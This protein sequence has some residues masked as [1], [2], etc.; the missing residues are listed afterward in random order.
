[1]SLHPPKDALLNEIIEGQWVGLK[2]GDQFMVGKVTKLSLG[3]LDIPGQ[4]AKTKGSMMIGFEIPIY[5]ESGAVFNNL[6]RLVDPKQEELLKTLMTE[7]KKKGGPQ[8]V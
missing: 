7:E 4:T 6:F 5:F 3:G 2:L 8:L 1:M